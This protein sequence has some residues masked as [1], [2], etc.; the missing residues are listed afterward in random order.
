MHLGAIWQMLCSIVRILGDLMANS[1]AANAQES[2]SALTA[3][4]AWWRAFTAQRHDDGGLHGLTHSDVERIAK[5]LGLRED[6]LYD[7][8]A[9]GGH[10]ADQAPEMMRALGLDPAEVEASQHT[11]HGDVL[12]TCSRC[13]EKRRCTQDLK[14]GTAE[15]HF[16]EYCLNANTLNALRAIAAAPRA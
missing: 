10:A 7:L 15:A 8:A 6:D 1:S 2:A 4:G 12:I 5:D 11:I 9:K 3:L 16:E 14:A 13:S